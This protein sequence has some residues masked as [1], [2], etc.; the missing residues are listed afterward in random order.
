MKRVFL[1]LLLSIFSLQVLF[2]QSLTP[3]R[4]RDSGEYVHGQGRAKTIEEAKKLSV[5]DLVSNISVSVESSYEYVGSKNNNN[6]Q[7]DE[8]VNISQL[9]HTYSSIQNLTNVK[10]LPL[11]TNKDKDGL[12]TV[13]SYISRKDLD[14]L[15]AKRKN[16]VLEYVASAV[17]Y[18]SQNRIG[19]AIHHYYWALMLLRTYPDGDVLYTGDLTISQ[20][21]SMLSAN[22]PKR[23]AIDQF[24]KETGV[25]ERLI[26]W[27]PKKI[28]LMAEQIAWSVDDMAEEDGTKHLT[29]SV[30]YKDQPVQ[31]FCYQYYDGQELSQPRE[32]ANADGQ[33]TLELFDGYAEKKVRFIIDYVGEAE[34]NHDSE[35]AAVLKNTERVII[36]RMDNI[37]PSSV[38]VDKKK[39]KVEE[40]E[41]MQTFTAQ[42]SAPVQ[43]NAVQYLNVE[44]SE[45]YYEAYQQLLHSLKVRQYDAVRPLCTDDGWDQFSRLIGYGKARVIGEP[46]ILFYDNDGDITCRKIPMSFS[47]QTNNH[48]TF[49]EDVVVHFNREHLITGVSFALEKQAADDILNHEADWG[50]NVKM[51][52]V[53]FLET[54]KTAYALRRLDYL[55]QIFSDDALIIVGS[56][57]HVKKSG[58][59]NIP[60]EE[61][62][63]YTTLTKQQYMKNLER[64]FKSNEFINIKFADNNVLKGGFRDKTTGEL[65]NVFGIQVKQDYFSSHYGDTG[66]L[67]LIVDMENPHQPVVHVRTWQAEKDDRYADGLIGLSDFN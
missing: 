3:D 16:K 37:A 13:Y 55:K 31:D 60:N 57:L 66:Y 1:S 18:E 38:K 5:V 19:S 56:V 29:V 59:V 43:E 4:L 12:Y 15:F 24:L 62:I 58:E 40:A 8:N 48:R 20:G 6:G 14:E 42:A 47:F 39:K 9:L 22:S 23:S 51:T 17:A 32:I 46:E 54:Y 35:L 41:A 64:C 34:A 50:D 33:G 63:N 67:F 25:G 45:P 36:P 2:S 27:I 21:Y 28:Q 52:I 11:P 65:K 44:Q 49:T 61:K 26:L 7:S 53:N 10:Q 30:R